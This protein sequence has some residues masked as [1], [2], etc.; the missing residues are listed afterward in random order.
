MDV[1]HAEPGSAVGQAATPEPA[2]GPGG[3]PVTL[4]DTEQDLEE[5]GRIGYGRKTP[6]VLGALLVLAVLG[7]GI[8]ALLDRGDGQDTGRDPRPASDFALTLL[9]GSTWRLSDHRGQVVVVNFW[10]SWC[11]PCKAEMPAFQQA[12]TSSA[13]DVV[14]VGVGSKMDRDDDVRAF[15][16]ATGVTYP[17]GR[18]LA[19]GDRARGTI[20]QAYG[21]IGYPATFFIDPDGNISRI[22][23]GPLDVGRLETYIAEARSTP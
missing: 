10:A 6:R 8:A 18:D 4:S 20:E 9:D 5:H 13:G 19:G 12:A 1:H 11:E 15:I 14:F 3:K 16:D 23:M 2:V 7:L 21:V 22:E 17:V